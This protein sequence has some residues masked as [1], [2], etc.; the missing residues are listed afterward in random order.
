MDPWIPWSAWQATVLEDVHLE[1]GDLEEVELEAGDLEE[2]VLLHVRHLQAS[3]EQRPHQKNW[4]MTS[5]PKDD[6]I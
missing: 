1:A 4:M 6:P 3:S 5:R 2:V